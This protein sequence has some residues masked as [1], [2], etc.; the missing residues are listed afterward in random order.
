MDLNHLHLHVRD[1]EKS[2]SFYRKYF[3]FGEPVHHD[4]DDI[5]FLNNAEGFNL[6]LVPDPEPQRMPSWFHIGFRLAKRDDVHAMHERMKA[7]GV[8]LRGEIHE[9]ES[10]TTFRCF[11]PDGVSVEVFWE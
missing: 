1:I 10:Y 5:A 3:E 9:D 4:G 7:D 8:P 6:A 2:Q 11:D